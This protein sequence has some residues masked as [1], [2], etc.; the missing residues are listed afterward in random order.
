[1]FH[2]LALSPELVA[3]SNNW[4]DEWT[5]YEWTSS[6]PDAFMTVRVQAVVILAKNS[7]R[8]KRN[9]KWTYGVRKLWDIFCIFP[10]QIISYED[11]K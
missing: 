10:L 3:M 11:G 8:I 1:M 5:D 2:H 6:M 7:F 4:S 9:D